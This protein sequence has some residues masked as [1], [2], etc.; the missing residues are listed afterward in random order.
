M[1]SVKTLCLAAAFAAPITVSA[2]V[3]LTI[4]DV[5]QRWPWNNKV[6]ITYTI[7][8]TIAEN[9]I[10]KVMLTSVIDGTTYI[11]YDGSPNVNT[12]P[13]TYTVTWENPPAGVKRDNCQMTAA[14][15]S[16]P[17]RAGDDYMI[18][19]LATGAVTYEGVFTAD[20]KLGNVSGQELSNARY[21]IDKY[22]STHLVLRKVPKGTYKTGDGGTKEW[23]TD[24]DYYIG[25]F[26][27]TSYQYWQVL[28]FDPTTDAGRMRLDARHSLGFVRDIRGDADPTVTPPPAMINNQ[29]YIIR[30]LNGR[31]GMNF[32]LPTEL[33][34]E[35][36]TRAGTTT[37]YYWGTDGNLASQYAVFGVAAGQTVWTKLP[38]AWGLYDTVGNDWEW[39][40]DVL[41]GEGAIDVFT[42]ATGAHVNRIVRGQDAL[43][44][45][46]NLKSS[47]RS[48]A[49]STSATYSF[50][51]AYIVPNN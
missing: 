4:D 31:T 27:W 25:V 39:C 7:T 16:L 45:G 23:T 51:I 6:D 14:F 41:D 29:W 43:T 15:Y 18:V 1:K 48:S 49:S 42:P 20:D 22:K 3:T 21:N 8:G 40:L 32:D 46:T 38:N 11:A 19:D 37:P 12:A 50:R 44:Q 2:A 5:Q 17:V 9:R 10:G 26:P 13:G 36:A 28:G 47:A 24:K 34:H 35:I 33:M 30:W